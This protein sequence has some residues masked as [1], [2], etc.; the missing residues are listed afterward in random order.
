MRNFFLKLLFIAVTSFTFSCSNNE[1]IS[2]EQS[3]TSES[4]NYESHSSRSSYSDGSYCADIEYYNPR[5]GTNSTYNLTVDIED[6]KLVK[7]YWP[8]G[9]WLDESHYSGVEISDSGDASFESD[10]GYQYTLHINDS[11]P[12]SF[13]DSSNIEDQSDD[14][15]ESEEDVD[16][17]DPE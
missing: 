9:G 11:N 16:D 8:N 10:K 7:I 13:D 14:D 5:T 4:E 2:N 3:K 12:C 6:G 1:S 17:S 15:S